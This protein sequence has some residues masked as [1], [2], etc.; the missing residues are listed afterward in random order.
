MEDSHIIHGLLDLETGHLQLMPLSC[1]L[2]HGNLLLRALRLI[3][4][5]TV[6]GGPE[7]AQAVADLYRYGLVFMC[8]VPESQYAVQEIAEKI[9]NLQS[10]FYGLTWDVISKAESE[11][12]A[13]AKETL[14]LQQDLLYC[15]NPPKVQILH[16]L[17]NGREG[18]DSLFSD[19]LRTANDLKVKDPRSYEVLSNQTIDFHYDKEGHYYWT[20][21]HVIQSRS[22][23]SPAAV[24]W[25]P[26]F[27]GPFRFSK[28]RNPLKSRKGHEARVESTLL[29]WSKAARAFRHDVESPEN[30]LQY[31]LKPGDCVIFDNTRILHGQT[32]FD[33]GGGQR[34]LRGAYIDNQTLRSAF[35]GI[36]E[37]NLLKPEGITKE[38]WRKEMEKIQSRRNP[39]SHQS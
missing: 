28:H 16:C 18:G 15:S 7:F 19:G 38:L 37:K 23:G 6:G 12:V 20:S 17:E 39:G 22:S 21:R 35:V 10:T 14:C 31:R 4:N 33:G 27:Q 29:G 13:Y 5:T 32:K 24:A 26:P 34:H 8:G 25:S 2:R 30:M 1:S 11:D 9:G 36:C 3:K